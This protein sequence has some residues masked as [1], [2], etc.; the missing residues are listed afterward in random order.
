[1][2]R[3]AATLPSASPS[4][5]SAAAI[6]IG[7]KDDKDLKDGKGEPKAPQKVE[8]ELIV[9]DVVTK[10]PY[11]HLPGAEQYQ[12]VAD[13]VNK[14]KVKNSDGKEVPKEL[15]MVRDSN[16]RGRTIARDQYVLA[17]KRGVVELVPFTGYGIARPYPRWSNTISIV[18]T[19]KF[20]DPQNPYFGTSDTHIV[21]VPQMHY[22]RVLVGGKYQLLGPG[23][24]VFTNTPS[25]SYQDV[26]PQNS[27]LVQWGD[28]AIMMVPSGSIAAIRIG[29]DHDFKEARTE[30][31]VTH[32]NVFELM[33]NPKRADGFYD[34]TQNIIVNGAKKRILPNLWEIVV[35]DNGGH[36][37]FIKPNDDKTPH[38]ID[39]CTHYVVDILDT[40]IRQAQFPDEEDIAERRKQPGLKPEEIYYDVYNIPNG[41]RI[42][43]K[44]D[45]QYQFEDPETLMKDLRA[46]SVKKHIEFIVTTAMGAVMQ[47]C[48]VTDFLA[49]DK[50]GPMQFDQ[51]A[52]SKGEAA[53][54]PYRHFQD[55]MREQVTAAFK[56]NG[57][58]LIQLSYELPKI[59]DEKFA[60][61]VSG[62]SLKMAEIYTQQATTKMEFQISQQKAE[63]EARALAI[64][65]Q[66]ENA[67]LISAAQ[68]KVDAAKADASA[69]IERAKGK[70]AATVAM[71]E[72]EQKA[73]DLMGRVYKD[74]PALL[75]LRLAEQ[76][77]ETLRHATMFVGVD[78]QTMFSAYNSPM[79]L[80]GRQNG[81]A[82]PMAAPSPSPSSVASL[83]VVDDQKHAAAP[84]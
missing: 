52:D 13:A 82:V 63:R 70:A 16:V 6:T 71:A 67:N 59:L 72:A 19:P 80:F 61:Q 41:P 28:I 69:E 81:A 60:Q 79:T 37:E 4:P 27:P 76:Q 62:N 29:A 10:S 3:S 48:S 56:K 39:S 40:S 78:P 34:A 15:F 46:S 36:I 11:V 18:S 23:P 17:Q 66:Q 51:K 31:Y 55:I 21:C 33:K 42:A 12:A 57:I 14:A 24:H 32:S 22:G 5:S 54:A 68:A 25:F 45:V 2:L 49:T 26:V 1:M 7:L 73:A 8:K 84:K 75:Q 43:V 64:K 47:Q 58:K 65:Q 20:M 77:R 38:I 83:A 53:T 44:L 9:N 30:P 50:I 74:N 35:T